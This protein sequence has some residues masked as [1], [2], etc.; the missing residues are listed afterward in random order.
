VSYKHFSFGIWCISEILCFRSS[1]ARTTVLR[2]YDTASLCIW[3]PTFRGN[4]L[5]SY[6]RY[7]YYV[8]S[9]VREPFTQ[10]R[11]FVFQKTAFFILSTDYSIYCTIKWSWIVQY[12]E[13]DW[14]NILQPFNITPRRSIVVWHNTVLIIQTNKSATYILIVFCISLL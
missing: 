14:H 13:F 1:V 2:R 7:H 10:R 6:S 5:A 9:K 8:I 12:I 11:G 3:F 4:I